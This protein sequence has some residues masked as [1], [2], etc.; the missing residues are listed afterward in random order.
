[1]DMVYK[2]I[3]KKV[4][5][6]QE[7]E[8]II[9]IA[10]PLIGEEEMRNV[11]NVLRSGMLA[12][13]EVV[14]EFERQFARYIGVKFA[15]A[16]N[17]GTSALHTALAS[18]GICKNDDVI[19]TD[20]SFISGASSILLQ[21]AKPV[22][23]DIDPMT[24]NISVDV[25]EETITKKTRAIVPVH[26][27]GQPCEIDSIMELAEEH[28]LLVIED[29]C[30]AHGARYY[31]KMV[32]SIGDVGVFSFYPTKNMTTGEGG[33]LTT[34]NEEVATKARMIRN[35]GQS[36]RYL[37]KVLGYNYRMTNLA[38]AI[39]VEQLR[40]LDEFNE[41]RIR[42]AAFLTRHINKTGVSCPRKKDYVKHVFHQ[43]TIRVD[44][45]FPLS[46]DELVDYLGKK[47]IGCGIYYPLP[48]HRQPLFQN[49]GYVDDNVNCPVACALSEEVVS[50]PVHPGLNHDDLRY[51]IDCINMV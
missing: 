2:L 19:T 28:D 13:G 34:N 48:I 36:S 43:F 21:G 3:E 33:M 15:V 1:V 16:T 23:C 11:E 14:E 38:A 20:F 41:M 12:Q 26:L 4:D 29:A 42:N 31:N 49:L 40:R 5:K 50:L 30:Q 46:R 27:Y 39:G 35:H 45:G 51:I 8:R 7:M 10:Q 37:H 47:G 22:F 24:Y 6:K 25:L 18:L 17:S 9:P 44:E 32:G